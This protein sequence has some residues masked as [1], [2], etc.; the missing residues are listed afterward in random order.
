MAGWADG[1]GGFAATANLVAF[2]ELK[3]R[4][5][6]KAARA[7]SIRYAAGAARRTEYKPAR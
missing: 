2:I 4:M 1:G 7:R 3:N 6:N 5:F